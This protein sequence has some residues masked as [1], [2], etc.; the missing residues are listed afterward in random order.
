VAVIAP[1]A[2]IAQTAAALG[3]DAGSDLDVP[4]T[5]LTPELAKGFEFDSVVVV[6]PA[7]I[8]RASAR[9]RADLYMALTRTTRRLGLVSPAIC[10]PGS[11]LPGPVPW[12]G[13]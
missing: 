1:P 2:Q 3:L 8:E 7:G 13:G 12:P 10:H 4:V 9:G 11:R 6:D 5:V